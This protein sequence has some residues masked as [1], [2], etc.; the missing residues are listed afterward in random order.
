MDE[1]E[2]LRQE[3]QDDEEL[4]RGEDALIKGLEKLYRRLGPPDK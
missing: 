3:R 1:A 4:E 2:R